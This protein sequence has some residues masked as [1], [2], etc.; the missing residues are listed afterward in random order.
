MTASKDCTL[1]CW[2]VSY[3]ADHTPAASKCTAVCDAHTQSVAAV[4]VHK[5]TGAARPGV[6]RFAS[7]SWDNSVKLWEVPVQEPAAADEA[8]S[9]RRRGE[10]GAGEASPTSPMPSASLEGHSQAVTCVSWNAGGNRVVSGSYDH[11]VRVWDVETASCSR[12]IVGGGKGARVVSCIDTCPQEDAYIC[13]C[14]R[15]PCTCICI[16][17]VGVDASTIGCLEMVAEQTTSRCGLLI[18]PMQTARA[19]SGYSDHVVRLWD[20]RAHGDPTP[21]ALVLCSALP[22]AACRVACIMLCCARVLALLP[23][24]VLQR[25]P[26][27]LCASLRTQP[28]YARPTRPTC[29][30]PSV[31]FVPATAAIP[32][33][34]QPCCVGVCS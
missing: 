14:Y 4:S 7:G 8:R 33:P 34:T 24:A 17:C 20:Q 22:H 9:K 16:L 2:Q 21:R 5:P 31:A 28:G 29:Q 30:P 3:D 25:P 27:P 13:A 1:R 19:V 18:A 26:C 32:T 11:S 6:C 10:S 15:L 23:A 12:T